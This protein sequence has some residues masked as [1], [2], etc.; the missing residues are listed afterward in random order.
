MLLKCY[1]RQEAVMLTS[2]E[3]HAMFK[4]QTVHHYIKVFIHSLLRLLMYGGLLTELELL[5]L[6]TGS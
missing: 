5:I 1:T 4:I 6:I 2:A 3:L